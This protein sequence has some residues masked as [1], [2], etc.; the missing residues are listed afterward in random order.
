MLRGLVFICVF[1]CLLFAL[2]AS[3]G[4]WQ[5]GNKRLLLCCA[6]L[7]LLGYT[8]MMVP[9]TEDFAFVYLATA[10]GLA[11]WSRYGWLFYR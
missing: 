3:R 4:V 6:A 8:L 5:N 2:T 11:W 7:L 1:L 10:F 9:E